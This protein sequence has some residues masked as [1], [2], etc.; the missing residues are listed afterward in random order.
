MS[1][2]E[3]AWKAGKWYEQDAARQ[4]SNAL[5]TYQTSIDQLQAANYYGR[6]YVPRPYIVP[7]DETWLP[8]R[9]YL[10]A[11]DETWLPN[12]RQDACPKVLAKSSPIRRSATRL[13]RGNPKRT[14]PEHSE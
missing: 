2:F 11:D 14:A 13:H 8:A 4:A 9:G 7:E 1:G 3:T 10:A 6:F 12:E 5:P